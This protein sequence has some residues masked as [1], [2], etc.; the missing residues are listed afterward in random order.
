MQKQKFEWSTRARTEGHAESRP[1]K[2]YIVEDHPV[3]REGLAQVI[4]GEGDLQVCGTAGDAITARGQIAQLKPDIV[5]IDISLP[6]KSGLELIKEIRAAD[7]VMKLLVVSM[8]DE[9]LYANRVLRMGGDGYIMKEEG[10]SEILEAIRDVLNGHIYLSED[11]L[12]GRPKGARQA[13]LTAAAYLLDRLTDQELEILELLGCGKTAL[14][15]GRDIDA[16][17]RDLT[18]AC[19]E[20]RRKLGLRHN[21]ALLRYAVCWVETGRTDPRPETASAA[22]AHAFHG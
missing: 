1:R 15:I 13:D 3:Y 5:L 18:S 16:I 12:L 6:G 11:V 19:A 14:E 22:A 2:V 21:H 17:P 8:H 7:P 9:A 4:R 10:P 20:I